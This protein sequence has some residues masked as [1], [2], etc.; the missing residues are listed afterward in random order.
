MAAVSVKLQAGDVHQNVTSLANDSHRTSIACVY[1]TGVKL[2]SL[3]MVNNQPNKTRNRRNNP[4]VTFAMQLV[5]V[6]TSRSWPARKWRRVVGALVPRLRWDQL[7]ATTLTKRCYFSTK[8]HGVTPHNTA[9]FK[10]LQCDTQLSTRCVLTHY[11][12]FVVSK[13]REKSAEK[14]GEL[15]VRIR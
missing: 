6:A 1:N 4:S 12:T 15:P 11:P 3:C 9:T 10:K 7:P 5:T 13:I 8:L 2:F 14:K